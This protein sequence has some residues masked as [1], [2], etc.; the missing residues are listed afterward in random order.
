MVSSAHAGIGEGAL[1]AVAACSC[2][3]L[4]VVSALGAHIGGAADL[5]LP[6]LA[7]PL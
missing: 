4:V 1:S 7:T 3:L 2:A 6:T 5:M